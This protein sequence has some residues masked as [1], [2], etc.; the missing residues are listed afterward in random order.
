MNRDQL[1]KLA[2]E[3]IAAH[4]HGYDPF[5]VDREAAAD[6]V[7]AIEPVIRDDERREAAKATV[8]N[9]LLR[10]KFDALV[11]W[12]DSETAR[13]DEAEKLAAEWKTN[14]DLFMKQ[15]EAEKQHCHEAAVELERRVTAARAEG[16]RRGY[17]DAGVYGYDPDDDRTP[18]DSEESL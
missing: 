4:R 15:W 12:A 3:A 14:S 13:A 10:P 7:D 5:E 8:E 18:Y 16:Y 9:A 2:A 11:A 17:Q 1:I 6:V